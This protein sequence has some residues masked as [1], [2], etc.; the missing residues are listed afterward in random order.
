MSD[1]RGRGRL[2]MPMLFRTL[3][4][5]GSLSLVLGRLAQPSDLFN[6]WRPWAE[7]GALACGMS[8]VI[9]SGGI[10]LSVGALIGLC[11]VVLGTAWLK[12][13]CPIGLACV[14]AVLAGALG[15]ILNGGLVALGIAPWAATLATMACYSGLAMSL[16]GGEKV[17][18]FPESFTRIGQGDLL[19]WPSPLWLLLGVSA[20]WSVLLNLSRFGRSLHA[21]GDN[22][23]AARFAALPV[24]ARLWRLYALNGLLAGLVA[25]SWT[26][27]RDAAVPDPGWA[28]ELQVIGAAVLG[29]NRLGG[30]AGGI[31]RTLLGAAI[32]AHL[33]IGLVLLGHPTFRLPGHGPTLILDTNGRLVVIATVILAVAVLNERLAGPREPV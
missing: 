20:A 18:G 27:R 12:L 11:S 10:D 22:I 24:R 21:I 33:E 26:A 6:L 31:G 19:G 4:L 30:G 7:M 32:L 3:L 13:G 9:V 17:D 5:V 16:S 23:V 2:V 25:L 8:A 14:L 29:G 1:A 28:L 15:G